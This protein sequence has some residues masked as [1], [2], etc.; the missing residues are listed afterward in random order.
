MNIYLDI[1]GVLLASENAAALFADEFLVKVLSEYPENTYWLTTHNWLG[2][3]KAAERLTPYL[4]PETIKLLS[5]IQPTEWGD[6]KT[7]AI[8][9][10]QPFLW[11][12]DDLYDE[13]R[14]VLESHNALENWIGVNLAKDPKQL[15]KFIQSFPLPK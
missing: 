9:F 11:F 2:E 10:T 8:D 6:W 1:D 3:N 7:D 4:K 5:I 13:E 12:D 14:E 15:Q